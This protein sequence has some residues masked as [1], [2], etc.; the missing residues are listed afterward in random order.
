MPETN[1][2][3]L[4][5]KKKMS[6]IVNRYQ[7]GKVIGEGAYGKVILGEE[8]SSGRAVAIKIVQQEEM[9]KYAKQKAI[10]RE[11]NL[12]NEMSHPFIIELYT[13]K[14]DQ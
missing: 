12:L 1:E 8:I 10:F 13:T 11:K 14:L 2:V 7:A 3:H 6:T 5:P 9:A 4:L